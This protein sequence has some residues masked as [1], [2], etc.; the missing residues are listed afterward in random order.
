MGTPHTI[1]VTMKKGGAVAVINASDFDA[2]T[3]TRTPPIVKR[4]GG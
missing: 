3:H 4:G 2:A 1:K